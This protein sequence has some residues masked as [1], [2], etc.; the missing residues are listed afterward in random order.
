MYEWIPGHHGL[1]WV[2]DGAWPETWWRFILP[3]SPSGSLHNET[4]A[5]RV[6]LL[7]GQYGLLQQTAQALQ[8]QP[9]CE[10]MTEGVTRNKSKPS[11]RSIMVQ[12][13]VKANQEG[14]WGDKGY[15]NEVREQEGKKEVNCIW[16]YLV[17]FT[18]MLRGA[19]RWGVCMTLKWAQIAIGLFYI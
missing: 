11:S 13:L 3:W 9:L 5:Q 18:R 19:E 12:A 1:H 16:D 10:A 4:M 17:P 14:R 15:I 7:Y 8:M 6:C 2:G